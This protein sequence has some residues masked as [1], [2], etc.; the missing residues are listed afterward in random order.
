MTQNTGKCRTLV[1]LICLA[2]AIAWGQ[3]ACPSDLYVGYYLEDPLNNPEDPVPGSLFLNLPTDDGAFA[4]EMFFTYVGCQSQN[5]GT[6]AGMRLGTSLSGDWT[7]TVDGTSQSG[8]FSGSLQAPSTYT[9]QYTVDGGKQLIEVED[10]T[11]YYIAAFGRWVLTSIDQP[12]PDDQLLSYADGRVSWDTLQDAIAVQC[13]LVDIAAATCGDPN[14]VLWQQLA[15]A[16]LGELTVPTDQLATDSEYALACGQF[17]DQLN[18]LA[19]SKVS[20]VQG[21]TNPAELIFA[22]GFEQ[23]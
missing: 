18:Q 15:D 11:T 17:D 20:F 12:S 19:F 13:Q 8:S 10:C 22:D 23:P 1:T 4:G 6:V 21:G 16:T 14:A 2:P 7:G 3:M 5:I 9:G